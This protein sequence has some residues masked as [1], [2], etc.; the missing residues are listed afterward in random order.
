MLIAYGCQFDLT[1]SADTPTVCLIDVHSRHAGGIVPT[2]LSFDTNP[3]LEPTIFIDDFGNIARR[4]TAPAGSMRLSLSGL[5]R[6][7]G[8]LDR[9]DPKA[10]ALP[11]D[12]LPA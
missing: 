5:Y 8:S 4:F 12:K 11:V 6:T 2:S 3:K 9:R 1:F 10:R 7:D